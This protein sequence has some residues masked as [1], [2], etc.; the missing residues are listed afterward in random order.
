MKSFTT[1]TKDEKTIN[2]LYPYAD[3]FNLFGDKGNVIALLE[4]A[5]KLDI[6]LKVDIVES[7]KEEFKFANYDIV[8]VSPGE[9][10]A[11]R[12]LA[13]L[14]KIKKSDIE[15]FIEAG[16]YFVVIGTSGAAFANNTVLQGDDSFEG[17]GIMDVECKELVAPLGDDLVFETMFEE[18]M[19]EVVGSQIQLLDFSL[20][21]GN[22]FGKVIYGYG[23]N[24][25]Q[26]SSFKAEGYRK[27]NFIFTNTLGPFFAKNPWFV[28]NLFKNIANE[29]LSNEAIKKYTETKENF[30]LLG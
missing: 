17:L 11:A 30:G 27:N 15:A 2:L 1:F 19:I 23:N 13:E 24:N 4:L 22:A 3:V 8:L 5:K 26:N 9:I 20:N 18:K 21:S 10:R 29:R 14:W 12:K 28:V 25:E 7:F 6:N 16:K